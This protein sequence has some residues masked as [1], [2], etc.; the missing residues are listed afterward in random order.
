M[1]T[2]I[3]GIR[4][5]IREVDLKLENLDLRIIA[6]RMTF[7]TRAAI[8][9]NEMSMHAFQISEHSNEIALHT[10]RLQRIE[11]LLK[12]SH[13]TEKSAAAPVREDKQNP[14]VLPP[15]NPSV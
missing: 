4:D 2:E 6:S 13:A 7:D 11:S 5:H 9:E 8:L 15:Q 10:D 1:K 14:S 3:E 12:M